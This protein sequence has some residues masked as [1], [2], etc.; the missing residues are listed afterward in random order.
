VY[1]AGPDLVLAGVTM[2]LT[3]AVTPTLLTNPNG[4]AR[5]RVETSGLVTIEADEPAGYIHATPSHLIT[6]AV[7]G[8]TTDV[9]FGY[10]STTEAFAI[11]FGT[12]YDDVN[13]NKIYD[14]GEVGIPGATVASPQ[15]A[16]PGSV[17]TGPYGWYT[18]RFDTE[19]TATINE[20]NAA[21]YVS[22][23]SDILNADIIIPSNNSSPFDFGDF[24]GV[25]IT[26]K[27]FNDLNA[28]GAD[29]SELGLAGVAVTAA[30]ES[31]QTTPTA[32]VPC[33]WLAPSRSD[34]HQRDHPT[35]THR[36]MRSPDSVAKVA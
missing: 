20:T 23:T 10:I 22:T 5:F 34:H 14:P 24:A 13:H 28:N 8:T 35:G 32:C 27:V 9:Y 26:G 4:L 17:V 25:K 15:A 31:T 2:T 6:E 16:A 30:L 19:G 3:Q 33:T 18:L 21:G 11:I 1:D 12:V 29:D 7:L 36:P